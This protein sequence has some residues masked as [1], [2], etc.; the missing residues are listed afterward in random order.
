MW[1]H[2]QKRDVTNAR[3]AIW[4]LFA[5]HTWDVTC[6][7]CTQRTTSTSV[8]CVPISLV[9]W[10]PW[11]STWSPTPGKNCTGANIVLRYMHSPHFSS[12]TCWCTKS[13]DHSNANSAI[14]HFP[15]FSISALICLGILGKSH[16]NVNIVMHHI[17]HLRAWNIICKCIQKEKPSRQS[18]TLNRKH[19]LWTG[20]SEHFS[21]S[22]SSERI[23]L[24]ILQ[25][26]NCY[27]S[28][29][30]YWEIMSLIMRTLVNCCPTAVKFSP[31]NTRN[32]G[33]VALEWSM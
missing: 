10:Q 8:K 24:Y 12:D 17:L 22:S 32:D 15:S 9:V 25:P 11:K 3:S 16:I 19:Q 30:Y 26:H 1:R 29:C 20:A 2:I 18:S 21:N 27:S 6:H 28:E 5:L 7:L 14:K 23:V 4:H 31:A 13:I 33:S